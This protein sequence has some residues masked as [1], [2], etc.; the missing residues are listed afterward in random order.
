MNSPRQIATYGE[1]VR[2][3]EAEERGSGSPDTSEKVICP[4]CKSDYIKEAAGIFS[5]PCGMRVDTQQDK[6]TIDYFRQRLAEVRICVLLWKF[7]MLDDV[8]LSSV[9]LYRIYCFSGVG[10]SFRKGLQFVP[11]L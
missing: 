7:S 4:V 11:R 6:M 9:W 10:T 1:L 3:A 2:S 5:C 8:H